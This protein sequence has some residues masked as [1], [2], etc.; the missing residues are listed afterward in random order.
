VVAAL[1]G[2]RPSL[3]ATLG[4]GAVLAVATHGPISS[5]ILMTGLTGRDRSFILPLLLVVGTATI[6]ARTI[7]PR[8]IYGAGLTDE[9]V[10]GRRRLR[11]QP[12]Q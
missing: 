11:D 6:V 8:S 2:V 7:E 10:E 3:F 5:M 9:R 1:A 4:A 12:A